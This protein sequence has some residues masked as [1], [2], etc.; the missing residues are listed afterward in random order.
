MCQGSLPSQSLFHQGRG[1][2]E[3]QARHQPDGDCQVAIPF[4][5]GAG[6]RR[7]SRS[8]RAR[9]TTDDRNPFFIRGRIQTKED[10]MATT[11][12]TA[13]AIPF[14][15]GAGFRL[16]DCP[17]S[18]RTSARCPNPFFVRGSGQVTS[19]QFPVSDW[20]RLVIGNWH[21]VTPAQAGHPF[22]IRADSIVRA[23]VSVALRHSKAAAIPFS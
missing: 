19:Y 5:P 8:W 14:S 17:K 11:P 7:T 16:N 3:A 21:L 12:E 4:S 2:D 18:G 13:V 15:S 22:F 23:G 20:L 10:S 9:G 1:S 6:F